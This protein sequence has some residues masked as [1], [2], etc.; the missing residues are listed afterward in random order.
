MSLDPQANRIERERKKLEEQ[1]ASIPPLNVEFPYRM[2]P[3][4]LAG[5]GLLVP[6][7]SID[8]DEDT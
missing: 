2:I 3:I 4:D 7:P 8:T 6:P 5:F 1:L